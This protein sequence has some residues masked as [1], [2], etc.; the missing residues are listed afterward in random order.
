MV[1]R[2]GWTPW[3][4]NPTFDTGFDLPQ[5]QL[6]V[7]GKET[8]GGCGTVW[9]RSLKPIAFENSLERLGSRRQVTGG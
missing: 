9:M 4:R 6:S 3:P 7:S 8:L 2:L 1:D 5:K